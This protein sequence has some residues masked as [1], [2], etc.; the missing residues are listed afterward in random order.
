MDTLSLVRNKLFGGNR[1]YLPG[2]RAFILALGLWFGMAGASGTAAGIAEARSDA[3]AIISQQEGA[4]N[5]SLSPASHTASVGDSFTLDITVNAGTNS[6]DA[7]DAALRFPSDILEVL[8]ITAGSAMPT[9]LENSFNNTSGAVDYA[10]GVAAG[11]P[12]VSGEFILASVQ[13]RA[14]ATG[15]ATVAFREDTEASSTGKVL[16][17]QTQSGTVTVASTAGPSPTPTQS[18]SPTES[19]APEPTNTAVF[20]PP[21][22][23]ILGPSQGEEFPNM[24]P[25]LR[26]K[27]S[28][29]TRQ[30][31]I[32]VIPFNNDGPGIDLIIGDPALVSEAKYQV[33]PPNA[34]SG[35]NY[36]LLPG[37][38]YTWRIRVATA[39]HSLDSSSLEWSN[40]SEG[41]FRTGTPSGSS[42]SP[43]SPGVG[44]RVNSL[45][46]V[47]QWDNTDPKI[48]YYEVQVSKDPSFNTDAATAVGMVYWELRHG[49]VTSPMNSYAVPS[50]F[51]LEPGTD[52]FWRVRPR[53]QGDGQPVEWSETWTFQ[54]P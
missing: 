15:T 7:I 19:P 52:Y 23:G 49:G 10:A 47:L 1:R 21:A 8:G 50:N 3:L 37:M 48:Y 32:H 43:I 24:D 51:P 33:Q 46:P 22:P 54:A 2:A 4:I 29:G 20:P 42:V 36:V 14:K 13:F 11:Q 5:L 6:V 53:V 30:F 9:R 41:S 26:W 38:S 34:G 12:G 35:S 31:Q 16:A 25:L 18:P 39:T 45:T 27:Q 44:R 17:L 40:W 28:E